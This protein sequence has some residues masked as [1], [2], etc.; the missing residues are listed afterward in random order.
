MLS[1]KMCKNLIRLQR[2]A[3]SMIN[4]FMSTDELFIKYGILKFE[5]LVQLE[6]MKTGYKLCNNLLPINFTT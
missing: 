5:K 3:V 4:P 2:I 1:K 6:Q